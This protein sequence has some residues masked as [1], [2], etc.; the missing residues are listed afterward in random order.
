MTIRIGIVS[1]NRADI[2]PKAID[3]ALAQDWP[4][5]EVWVIDDASSD[6]TPALAARYPSVRWERFESIRGYRHARNRMMQA[7]GADL[8]CSLD[9][10][11][12]FLEQDAL[13][14]GVKYFMDFPQLG[15][16]AY[17][18]VEPSSPTLLP[19]Q[20]LQQ[21]ATFIGCGHLLRLTSVAE[22]GFYRKTPGA[23]GVEEKDL[24]LRLLDHGYEVWKLTGVHVWHDKTMAARDL[25]SQHRSG[26]CND[27][28]FALMR[29]PAAQLA[30][31]LPGKILRHFAFAFYFGILPASSRNA[32]DLQV[33]EK[34]GRWGFVRPFFLGLFDF[35][36]KL[37]Q[38]FRQRLPVGISA[39]QRASFRT[40]VGGPCTVATPPTSVAVTI[41]T[42]NRRD[43]LLAT[44]KVLHACDPP[45]EEIIVCCDGCTDDSATA[46]AGSFPAVTILSHADW[47]GSIPSRDRMMRSVSSTLVC[48]LDDDSYPIQPDFFARVKEMFA[49]EPFA[50]VFTFPQISD[51]FPESLTQIRP[52]E[53]ERAL[54]GSFTNSGAAIRRDVYLDLPGYATVFRHAYEEPDFALQCLATGYRVIHEPTAT[55][56]HLY[57]RI[58]R[59]ELRTHQFHARNELWSVFLR[60]PFPL[61]PLVAPFR[62]IRQA[63]YAARRGPLWLLKE[64]L[65]W[66]DALGG[67]PTILKLRRPVTI[68]GY[69]RWMQRVRK[70]Q[71]VPSPSQN[72]PLPNPQPP[73]TTPPPQRPT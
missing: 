14:I 59:N 35:L 3:S 41:T 24:S 4:D 67:L 22:A 31:I 17:Q 60:C 71:P 23:Y 28:S 13:R 1:H 62:I 55:I 53:G 40:R 33:V 65:W 69:W 20:G 73:D 54:V 61:L 68:A 34:I 5:K 63:L 2:L 8:F 57:S 12:W 11:S 38:I 49:Q 47:L 52:Q 25:P 29:C 42:R 26:V 9:D 58:S 32:F 21:A 27:L 43:Q 50:A 7:P 48:S 66:L 37:P 64:P 72:I 10:D 16:I 46:A 36:R 51:E 44:L 56:R 19:R 70:P 45:P 6:D 15:A 39:W 30:L 18:I